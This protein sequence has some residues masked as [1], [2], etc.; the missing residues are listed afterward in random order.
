MKKLL[1]YLPLPLIPV[2]CAWLNRVFHTANGE[3]VEEIA[4]GIIEGIGVDI[5]YLLILYIIRRIRE[6]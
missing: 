5:V 4:A 1:K 6:K 2:L 3:K